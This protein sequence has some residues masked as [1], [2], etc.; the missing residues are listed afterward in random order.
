M[1][2]QDLWNLRFGAIWEPD[3]AKFLVDNTGVRR[4][5]DQELT[6][7]PRGFIVAIIHDNNETRLINETHEAGT[8]ERC[9]AAHEKN[10]KY[11]EEEEAKARTAA[12][13][14]PSKIKVQPRIRQE[15]QK[16]NLADKEMKHLDLIVPDLDE[17]SE[18]ISQIDRGNLS[19]IFRSHENYFSKVFDDVTGW[20]K[21][22]DI[23]WIAMNNN[24]QT[25]SLG[26]RTYIYPT[27]K[28][29]RQDIEDILHAETNDYWT[30][31]P[32]AAQPFS[33]AV[34]DLSCNKHQYENSSD[35]DK[36]CSDCID[37]IFTRYQ[38]NHTH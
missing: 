30:F 1:E 9:D 21:T 5:I 14:D 7:E 31:Y 35:I 28:L 10:K 12:I 36:D 32:V 17:F 26:G 18:V 37:K 25:S 34:E 16:Y 11:R 8:C 13:W 15:H 38:Q 23:P 27:R 19:N 24:A 4:T 6:K 3:K 2:F 29:E 33:V 22:S 20:M